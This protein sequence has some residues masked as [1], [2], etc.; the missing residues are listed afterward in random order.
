MKKITL[1]AFICFLSV[2]NLCCSPGPDKTAISIG[3]IK[4]SADEFNKAFR[5]SIY[6]DSPTKENRK[7]FLETFINRKLILK[8][9]ASQN[10]DK[11]PRF[12]ESIQ[13]FWEQSLMKLILD[14]K[15]KEL[16]SQTRLTEQEINNYYEAHREDFSDKQLSEVYGQVKLQL[17]ILKQRAAL[18]SWIRSL[19]DKNTIKADTK[20][21]GLD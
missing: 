11:D 21:L 9:A 12:L 19:K 8:E 20:L 2:L 1:V 14:K 3:N 4:F 7:L 16:S 17:S 13:I 10:M 18:D 15:I 5:Q 6:A